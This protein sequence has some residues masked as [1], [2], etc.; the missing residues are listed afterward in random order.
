MPPLV[1]REPLGSQANLGSH[2]E[3][4]LVVCDFQEGKQL[5][6]HDLH[7]ALVDQRIRQLER[8]SSD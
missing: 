4:K 5:P 1:G 6:D 7:I 2:P 8:S 3:L